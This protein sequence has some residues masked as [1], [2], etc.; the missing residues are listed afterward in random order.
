MLNVTDVHDGLDNPTS[1]GYSTVN[2]AASD[3]SASFG[4]KKTRLSTFCTASAD[5]SN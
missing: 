4:T 2:G 3:L 5:R 1:A